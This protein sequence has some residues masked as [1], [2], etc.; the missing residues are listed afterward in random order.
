MRHVATVSKAATIDDVICTILGNCATD[1]C[2]ED[3]QL[4]VFGKCLTKTSID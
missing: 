3:N 2:E 1:R 4:E